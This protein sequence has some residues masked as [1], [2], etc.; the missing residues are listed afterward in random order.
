MNRVF[1]L[2]LLAAILFSCSPQSTP[3]PPTPTAAPTPIPSATATLTPSPIPPTAT[4]T[5]LPGAVVLPVD[6]LG[7]DIPW[8]PLDKDKRPRV[9]LVGFNILKPPFNSALVRQAFAYAIDRQVLIGMAEKY[10]ARDLKL[11][12]TLTPPQTLGRDLS[13]EIGVVF[14]PQKAK[15]LFEEAGYTDPTA[16]PETIIIVS[17]SGDIAPGARFNMASAMARMWKDALG[18]SVQVEAV[19]S[20]GDYGKR[21]SSNP[22]DMFWLGWAADYNDPDNFLREI[23]H[24][25]TQYN[26]GKFSNPEF[27]RIVDRAAESKDPAQRQMLYIEAERLLCET[28]AALIPIYH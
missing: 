9:H 13:G 8:L 16:F 21:I 2:P 11:A 12:T 10:G 14:D 20:F 19:R 6:T 27:D 4:S 3:A 22:P 26:Y 5:P 1:A 7:T 24:S 28:E 25:G 18:V 17:A 23:F 15:A